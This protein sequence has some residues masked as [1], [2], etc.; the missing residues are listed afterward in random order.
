MAK[1]DPDNSVQ[2][3]SPN[4][5]AVFVFGSGLRSL[6]GAPEPNHQ[7]TFTADRDEY[8]LADGQDELVVTLNW[9]GEDNL[10]AQKDL[11]VRARQ[12]CNRTGTG[13]E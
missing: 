1:D 2:L 11:S 7:N 5:S 12:L 13:H 6:D 9:Q 3:L 8:V 4:P 10:T